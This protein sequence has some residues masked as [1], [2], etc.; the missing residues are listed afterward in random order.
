MIRFSEIINK[1]LPELEKINVANIFIGIDARNPPGEADCPF[2]VIF[3]GTIPV[4]HEITKNI[5][6]SLDWGVI[7]ETITKKGKSTIYNG[8]F[9]ADSIGIEIVD[10]LLNLFPDLNISIEYEIEGIN[11]FPLMVGGMEINIEM[12]SIIGNI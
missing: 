6:L 9:D 1:W 12:P 3:P 2:I 7:N 11:H 5:R 4:G 8:I 10:S